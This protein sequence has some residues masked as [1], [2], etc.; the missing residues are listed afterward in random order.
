MKKES[1]QKIRQLQMMEINLQNLL[2][3]K[4]NLQVQLIETENAV[5]EL[6]NAGEEPYKIV[7]SIMVKTNKES[8]IK[9]LNSKKEVID[10]K[11]KSLENQETEIMENASKIQQEVLKE[12]KS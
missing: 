11:L 10:V 3:Q 9:E 5:N 2:I 7:G 12:E 1:E 8:L 6:N 4:R